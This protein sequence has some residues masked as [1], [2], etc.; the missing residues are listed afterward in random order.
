MKSTLFTLALIAL[1]APPTWAAESRE[2]QQLRRLQSQMQQIDAARALA[3]TE[4]TAALADREALERERDALRAEH[5]ATAQQLASERAARVAAETRLTALGVEQS[6]LRQRMVETEN[7]STGLSQKLAQ[8]EQ[9]LARTQASNKIAESELTARG[10]RLQRCSGN[11]W[12]LA[13]LA[14]ELM[15]KYRDKGCIDALAQA[16]PFTGTR[17]VE[18]ENLLEVWRDRVEASEL[19]APAGAPAAP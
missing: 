1:L 13:G 8:T 4:R 3:E 14:R 19:P 15:A 9:A 10:E 18:V 7:A 17:K 11:N 12:Q 16:E 6:T 5:A 2:K